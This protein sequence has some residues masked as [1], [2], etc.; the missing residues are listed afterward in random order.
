MAQ[1]VRDLVGPSF[2]LSAAGN[3]NVFAADTTIP[4]ADLQQTTHLIDADNR[5]NVHAFSY[6]HADPMINQR[7]INDTAASLALVAQ[8]RR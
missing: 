3:A 4:S 2:G 7:V 6:R 8:L 1:P 5:L